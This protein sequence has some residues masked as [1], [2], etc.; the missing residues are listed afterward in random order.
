MV[1]ARGRQDRLARAEAG[2]LGADTRE[3]AALQHRIDLVGAVVLVRRLR[4]PGLEAVDVHEE[5]RGREQ[6]QLLQ[7]GGVEAA[8]VEAAD[9]DRHHCETSTSMS[10]LYDGR[11]PS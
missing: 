6:V 4:L 10:G 1:D 8:Y 7:L 11:P 3:H 2:A 5:A 9:I